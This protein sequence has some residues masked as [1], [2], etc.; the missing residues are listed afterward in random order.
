MGLDMYLTAERS[1]YDWGSEEE[2]ARYKKIN[3]ALD[4]P[5]GQ[6]RGIQVEAGYWRKA[7][8]I[9]RWF[10]DNVQDGIDECQTSDV[11]LEKLEE[12]LI[13]VTQALEDH[14]LAHELL[15]AS[16]GFFFGSTDYDEWYFKDL[17][18]TK[19]VIEK[20]LANKGQG[21]SVSYRASW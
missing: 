7:N 18:Y 3:D 1:V 13:V 6:V 5:F 12:L 21:W 8:A 9:H 4:L 19:H 20:I 10:V 16:E 2:K 15:P 11:P 14:S 17:E